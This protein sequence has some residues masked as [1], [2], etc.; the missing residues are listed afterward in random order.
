MIL[1]FLLFNL[2]IIKAHNDL[3]K[4]N[5]NIIIVCKIKLFIEVVNVYN[6]SFNLCINSFREIERKKKK[7]E[8]RSTDPV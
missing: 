6:N 5:N 7:K 1:L 8:G 3:F 4:F 2:N